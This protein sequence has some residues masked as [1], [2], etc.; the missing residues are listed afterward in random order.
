MY[1]WDQSKKFASHFDGTNLIQ[2]KK[3]WSPLP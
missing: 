2:L 1:K 3:F